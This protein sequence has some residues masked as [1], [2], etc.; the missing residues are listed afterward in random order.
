MAVK[1]FRIVQQA[2]TMVIERLGKYH[3]TLQSGVDILWPFFDKPRRIQWRF[4]TTDVSGQKIIHTSDVESNDLRE[5]VYD[6]PR[7]NVITKDNV[8]MTID[9][10]LRMR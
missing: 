4:T 10:M 6:F 1:G 2:E 8:T 3:R 5:T 9:G 7:Q